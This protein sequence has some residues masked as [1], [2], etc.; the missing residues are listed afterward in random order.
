MKGSTAGRQQKECDLP[1]YMLGHMHSPEDFISSIRSGEVYTEAGMHS[2]W[3]PTY[4]KFEKGNR[5]R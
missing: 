4:S 2:G 5:A 3:T 1:S